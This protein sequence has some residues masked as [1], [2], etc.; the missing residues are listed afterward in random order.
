MVGWAGTRGPGSVEM[1]D[2]AS[3]G[4]NKRRGL[5]GGMA[6]R[7][8]RMGFLGLLLSPFGECSPYLYALNQLVYSLSKKSLSL[9]LLPYF[10][11]LPLTLLYCLMNI[12]NFFIRTDYII[13]EQQPIK[14]F[15]KHCRLNLD[16]IKQPGC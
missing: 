6:P 3:S 4:L 2:S 16:L 5:G 8:I 9:S 7:L 10:R 13:Y 12:I 11:A 15:W 14:L 1:D